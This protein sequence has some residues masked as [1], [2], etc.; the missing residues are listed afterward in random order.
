MPA[1]ITSKDTG[2]FAPPRF[3]EYLLSVADKYPTLGLPSSFRN[4]LAHRPIRTAKQHEVD[5][6]E[7]RKARLERSKQWYDSLLISN[8]K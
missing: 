7:H 1:I 8:A 4:N 6:A 2:V 3:A 5:L